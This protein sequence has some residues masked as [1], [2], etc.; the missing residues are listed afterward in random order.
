MA[1]QPPHPSFHLATVNMDC[2]DAEAMADFYGRLLGWEVTYRD[3]DFILMQDPAGGTGLSFQEEAWYQAPV[4]PERPGELTKMIHLDIKVN[5]L[6][7]AV[8]HALAAGARLAEHQPRPD[9]RIVLDP[10][11]HPFCLGVE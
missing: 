2:A 4:W 3:D 6:D 1:T 7:A 9:L 11:G 10:A 8:A 5:D